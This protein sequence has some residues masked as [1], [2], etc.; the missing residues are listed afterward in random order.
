MTA[1]PSEPEPVRSRG[2]ARLANPGWASARER[3][4]TTRPSP[5][6]ETRGQRIQRVSKRLLERLDAGTGG[7]PQGSGAVLASPR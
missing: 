7:V 3:A 1:R 6:S 4:A 2:G 5:A